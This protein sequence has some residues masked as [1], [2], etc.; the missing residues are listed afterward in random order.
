MSLQESVGESRVSHPTPGPRAYSEAEP[1]G[2]S[3]E[4]E[5]K[6]GLKIVDAMEEGQEVSSLP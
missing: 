1:F 3:T 2:W 4:E 5:M 6:A